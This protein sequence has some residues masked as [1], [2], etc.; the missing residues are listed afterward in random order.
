MRSLKPGKSP[1]EG[2]EALCSTGEGNSRPVWVEPEST[3]EL[4]KAGGAG[5]TL[6]RGRALHTS[7]EQQ[8]SVQWT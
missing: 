7:G 3:G 1:V 5:S 6:P 2:E 4:R 8:E